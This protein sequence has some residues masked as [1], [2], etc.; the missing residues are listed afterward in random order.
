MTDRAPARLILEFDVDADR[1]TGTVRDES[2]PGSG[3]PFAGW[4]ALTQ[5]IEAALEAARSPAGSSLDHD[6]HPA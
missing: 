3:E 2:G 5:T 1:I 6:H 4:M